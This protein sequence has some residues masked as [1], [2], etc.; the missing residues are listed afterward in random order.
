MPTVDYSPARRQIWVSPGRLARAGTDRLQLGADGHGLA[1]ELVD[2][3]SGRLRGHHGRVALLRELD[4]LSLQ[5]VHLLR[6][7]E[8]SLDVSS[9][10]P[11]KVLHKVQMI[12]ELAAGTGGI[13]KRRE[14]R[15]KTER[16]RLLR[17]GLD[18]ERLRDVLQRLGALALAEP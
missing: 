14:L 5:H 6:Q 2:P 18:V 11:G 15:P 4:H 10:H 16:S 17:I 12:L 9:E 3:L 13:G 7:R 1:L 8:A